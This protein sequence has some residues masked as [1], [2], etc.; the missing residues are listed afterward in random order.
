MDIDP[1]AFARLDLRVGRIAQATLNTKARTPAYKLVIDF[2]EIG[3]RQSSGQYTAL[4]TPESLIG[5][6]VVCAMNLGAM[7]IGGY[8][9]QVLV[10]GARGADGAPILVGPE[11]EVPLGADLF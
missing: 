10:V 4:Y 7:R 8:E 2:G 3:T 5:R 11:R 1:Q 9:A 6:Q